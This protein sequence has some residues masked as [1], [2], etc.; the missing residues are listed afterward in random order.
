[1]KT[2]NSICIDNIKSIQYTLFDFGA[3]VPMILYLFDKNMKHVTNQ[4]G[5]KFSMTQQKFSEK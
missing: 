2:T 4:I 3:N 1:M 5:N